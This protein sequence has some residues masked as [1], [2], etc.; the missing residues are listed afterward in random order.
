MFPLQREQERETLLR[1]GRSIDV[2]QTAT[3]HLI[4]DPADGILYCDVCTNGP[5]ARG[6][7]GV[8]TYDFSLGSSFPFDEKL[9]RPFTNMRHAVL[10][11]FT[12]GAH[13]ANVKGA[14][15]KEAAREVRAAKC[16]DVNF[17]V[18]RTA[19][20]VLKHSEPQESFERQIVLQ[21]RN[22]I[23][24]G[25][26][27]HSKKTMS[28]ARDSFSKT[29]LEQLKTH[30]QEQPC[31]AVTADKVTINRR[32]VDITAV[33]TLVPGAAPGSMIQTFVVGAPVV[34]A[35][36]GA[37]QARQLQETLAA[38]GLTSCDQL[39]SI[40]ADGQYHKN[41]VP[42]LLVKNIHRDDPTSP[43][44]PPCVP[45]VW[46]SSHLINL[47]DHDAQDHASGEWV[48][49]TVE[50]MTELTKKFS[51]G[52]GNEDLRQ[53]AEETGL[54]LLQ[55]KLWSTTRFSA[56]AAEV[57]RTF[58]TNVPAMRVTLRRRLEEAKT[59][60]AAAEARTALRTLQG[61]RPRFQ[62]A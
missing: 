35:H 58:L 17:R 23:D 47:A 14:Q 20:S 2:L 37:S 39:S 50:K 46:D 40:A 24:M 57:A 32:T 6:A 13:K 27:G 54:Q 12:S 5:P 36:D 61:K 18:L 1:S 49:S 8:Y 44:R 59:G 3:E 22:G 10:E 31:V 30:F 55:P 7:S 28:K 52:K 45:A 43:A 38:V 60:I 4:A 15:E 25:D 9:P 26:I 48:R 19:Y 56:H 62:W 34:T 41:H 21:H 29:I 53:A 16:R 11:H 51:H 33:T 42:E